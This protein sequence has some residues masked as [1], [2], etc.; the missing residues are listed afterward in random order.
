MLVLLVLIVS[1]L[2]FRGLGAL[3]VLYFATWVDS[4]RVALA[5]MF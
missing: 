1:L 5:V 3:G 4:T 2:F